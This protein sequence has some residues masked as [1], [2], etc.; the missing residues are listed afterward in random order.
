VGGAV[1]EALSARGLEVRAATREPDNYRSDKHVKPVQLDYHLPETIGPALVGV[2]GLFLIALPL[3]PTAPEVLAPVIDRAKEAGV[4]HIILHS[5]FGVDMNEGAPLRRVEHYLIDS[6]VPYTILRSNFF[7]DNFVT[8]SISPMIREEDGIFLSAGEGK[9]SFIAT[10]DIAAVAAAAFEQGLVGREFNLTGNEALD[11][12]MVAKIIGEVAGRSIT[13]HPVS[14]KD[15]LALLRERGLPEP[16]AEYLIGLYALVRSGLMAGLT[17]DVL[18]V[19]GR[20][21]KRFADF[22]A[23]HGG[24]WQ[25]MGEVSL[26]YA[27]RILI[28]KP[29]AHVER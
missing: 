22:T 18:K 13:Y 28:G 17:G 12:Y 3:D 23:E 6:G 8:G 5:A 27:S 19:T 7:M 14:E 4:K 20:E 2:D 26:P 9:T 21:P 1:V 29:G 16:A 24:A 15:F 11:H 25:S 10:S